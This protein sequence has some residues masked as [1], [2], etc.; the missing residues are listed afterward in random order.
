M[1]EIKIKSQINVHE[2]YHFL[3]YHTYSTV[4]GFAGILISVCAFLTF[5]QLLQNGAD[6][7]SLFVTMLTA[8]LFLCVQPVRL[9]IQAQRMMVNDKGYANPITYT[10]G[11]NGMVV[12]QGD[13]E[14]KYPWSAVE[15]VI[16]TKKIIAVYMNDKVV[17]KMARRDVVNEYVAM[18]E[19]LMT[20]GIKG[21][22]K[23]K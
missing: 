20:V 14:A 6:V 21:T 19:M 8:L 22:V 12:A 13:A 9:Y 11:T 7:F 5:V 17:F 15:K 4:W 23:L 1:T 2:L 18:K 3:M 10:F 16:S